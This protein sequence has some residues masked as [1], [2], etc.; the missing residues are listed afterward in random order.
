MRPV[1]RASSPAAKEFAFEAERLREILEG[2]ERG[3]W[4]LLTVTRLESLHVETCLLS[5]CTAL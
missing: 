1:A 3:E 5:D 2:S 4:G